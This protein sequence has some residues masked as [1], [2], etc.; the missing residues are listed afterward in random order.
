MNRRSLTLAAVLCGLAAVLLFV[1]PAGAQMPE[2]KPKPP[3]YTYV[4]N[5]QV[6]RANWAEIEKMGDTVNPVLQKAFAD[7]TLVGYGNDTTLV[8]TADDSTHDNWWSSMS[9]AGLLKVLEQ[10]RAATPTDSAALNNAKHWDEIWQATYYNR[11][12]GSF[13]GAFTLVLEYKLKADAPD[14][15]LDNLSAHLI[16]PALE[17]L[18]ADGSVIEYEIDTMAIHTE[19]PGEFIVVIL[20]PT[21]EGIDTARAAILATAKDHPLAIQ[22]FGSATDSSA[23]RDALLR[24]DGA[25]K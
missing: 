17:K 25:Y 23:H 3:M 18:F 15:T 1:L 5:W 7:G 6:P 14:D 12:A 9:L 20:T 24:S 19:A 16:A 4:A 11:K 2:V 8:H 22:T 13:K 10:A 21:P